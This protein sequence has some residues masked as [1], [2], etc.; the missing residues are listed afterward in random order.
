MYIFLYEHWFKNNYDR[1]NQLMFL[2]N[3]FHSFVTS[4][5]HNS[6]KQPMKLEFAIHLFIFDLR[7]SIQ[8]E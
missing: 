8:R 3:I 5:L 1:N 2:I 6:I 4:S 7:L